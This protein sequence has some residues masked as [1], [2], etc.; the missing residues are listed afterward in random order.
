MFG[1]AG[2][3]VHVVASLP[4]RYI[5]DSGLVEIMGDGSDIVRSAID[6]Y[7]YVTIRQ[8]TG[9]ATE[10]RWRGRCVMRTKD[11]GDS[12]SSRAWGGSGFTVALADA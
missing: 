11:L 2:A 9:S 4:Y 7:F 1:H 5:P 3:A 6:D 10:R 8:E 12:H